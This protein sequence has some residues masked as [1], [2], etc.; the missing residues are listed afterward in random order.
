M[1]EQ[2]PICLEGTED[3]LCL[4]QCQHKFCRRCVEQ[5]FKTSILCPVCRQPSDEGQQIFDEHNSD[6]DDD[7]SIASD[8]STDTEEFYLEPISVIGYPDY[9]DGFNYWVRG[10]TQYLFRTVA[11]DF[12][13]TVHFMPVA[14]VPMIG[15]A[16]MDHIQNIRWTIIADN[17]V[18]WMPQ[19]W[20]EFYARHACERTCGYSYERL[21]SLMNSGQCRILLHIYPDQLP[22]FPLYICRRCRDSPSVFSNDED[23]ERHN[24]SEHGLPY[25]LRLMGLFCCR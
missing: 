25:R 8:D 13:A 23:L 24:E 16:S 21:V 17:T 11:Y 14:N 3:E 7:S 5:W 9:N 19:R 20:R 10:I 1:S 22:P 2:C 6:D 12:L 15:V 4:Q 18:N